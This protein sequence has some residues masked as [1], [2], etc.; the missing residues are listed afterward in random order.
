M[1]TIK[2]AINDM[3]RLCG[4]RSV[5]R[6]ARQNSN[7]VTT[8]YHISTNLRV[9][10]M[11][12]QTTSHLATAT[13]RSFQKNWLL[14]APTPLHHCYQWPTIS[15]W[16]YIST[17][18]AATLW[19]TLSVQSK[20]GLTTKIHINNWSRVLEIRKHGSESR[21]LSVLISAIFAII[22]VNLYNLDQDSSY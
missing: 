14:N 10:T 3:R 12:Y 5:K 2:Y 4:A 19:N 18:L 1:N 7:A 13:W 20:C 9:Q 16:L 21:V 8:Y 6:W 22:I 11:Y 15:T 17:E